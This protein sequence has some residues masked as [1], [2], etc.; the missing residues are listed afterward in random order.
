MDTLTLTATPIP[1]T[2]HMALAGIRE[3]SIISTAPADRLAIRTIVARES[4]DLIRDG[5]QRELKR[6]GQVFFVHN[7]VETIGK[8][9]RRLSASVTARWKP[10]S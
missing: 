10:R 5:I 3:I 2:L 1:R 8:W 6:G 9:A 7:R 4:D